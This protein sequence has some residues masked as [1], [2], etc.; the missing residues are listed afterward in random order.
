M[1]TDGS[2]RGNPG[3]TGLGAVIME[4]ED[5]QELSEYLGHGTNN[6]A[7]LTA[8]LRALEEIDD[9][10]KTVHLYTDS[11]YA[12]GVL[13]KGWKAKANG[14]LIKR[15]RLRAS[16]FSDLTLFKVKGHVGHA[17]NERVDLLAND[18]ID[19]RP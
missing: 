11:T 14:E 16:H 10:T 17:L 7:E 18:A 5:V 1:F 12:I 6:I 2:C 8:I 9:T 4:G 3:P 13:A 19:N 15:L